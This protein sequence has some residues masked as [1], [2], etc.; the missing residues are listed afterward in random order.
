MGRDQQKIDNL[1]WPYLSAPMWAKMLQEFEKFEIV[2]T[3]PDMVHN[4]WITLKMYPGNRTAT[5]IK[6][7]KETGLPT[8][9]INCK[10]NIIDC[11]L[12]E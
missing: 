7:S 12:V 4:N 1:Y 5:P 6:V 8:D 10:C 9:Y 2:V 3:F 11:G